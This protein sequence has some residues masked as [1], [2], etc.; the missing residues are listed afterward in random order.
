MRRQLSRWLAGGAAA[1]T[2]T[3]ASGCA[4]LPPPNLKP[5]TLGF[6]NFSVTQIG[7]ENIGFALTLDAN[8]P[9]AVTLPISNLNFDLALLGKPFAKGTAQDSSIQLPANAS[10]DVKVN[11][12][13]STSNLLRTV[14]NLQNA[15]L[16]NLSYALNGSANWGNTPLKLPFE[17]KGS[18]DV[19][20]QFQELMMPF[21]NRAK[22]R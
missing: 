19:L 18:L 13:I 7:F 8:N 14:A 22:P 16:E 21:T 6:K 10:S 15:G 17:R 3:V 20:R 1:I 9:N 4:S 12:V 2:L 5:P 11:F